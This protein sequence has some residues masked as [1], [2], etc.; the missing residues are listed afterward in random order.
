M[1]S[2]ELWADPGWR[3]I[4]DIRHSQACLTDSDDFRQVRDA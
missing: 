3:L 4:A 1:R 2:G